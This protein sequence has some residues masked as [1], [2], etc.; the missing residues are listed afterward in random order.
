VFVSH[1]G[2]GF[3]EILQED[4]K[5][6]SRGNQNQSFF[7]QNVDFLGDQESGQTS[8]SGNVTGLGDDGVTGKRIDEAV[9]LFLGL[10]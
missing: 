8:G 1:V 7:V 10:L 3:S 4:T 9:S 5:K 6:T 2:E